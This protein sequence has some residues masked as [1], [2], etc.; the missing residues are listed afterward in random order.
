[1]S[2][3]VIYQKEYPRL[4]YEEWDHLGD[5]VGQLKEYRYPGGS[6]A[7]CKKIIENCVRVLMPERL[8]NLDYFISVTKE[9]AD[10][11]EMDVLITEY[12]EI[13][14]VRLK[15]DIDGSFPALKR[16][17]LLTD[18]ISFDCREKERQIIILLTYYTH[19]I[20]RSGKQVFPEIIY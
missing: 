3:K 16:L 18:D 4:S 12:D 1:M 20:Y 17:I 14:T 7:L 15:L 13:I 8:E 11:Y 9:I 19:A 2:G 5:D 10:L 6:S